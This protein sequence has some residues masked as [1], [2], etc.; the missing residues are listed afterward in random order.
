MKNIKNY[1]FEELKQELKN[2]GEKPFRAEQIYKWLYEEKVKSFEEMTN[3]SKELREKLNNE[4]TI[5][6]FNILRKQESK[7]G[8]VKYLFDVLDGNAIETV[9]MKYHHG[10]S[11]CVSSQ[12]GCKMGCKFCASTGIQFI[13]SLSAGE[14]VE[15]VLAVEQDQNVRISNIVFMGIGE[16]LDNYD[17][18]VKAIR[19]INHP[20]GLNIGARHISI[21]TSGLVPKIYKL[22]EENIQC[23]LS[24]SLHATNNEKRSSMMP[25]NDAYPIEELIKA[26]KDY[27]KITNRRISFEY[28][29]AKDN[30]DNLEDAKEL[31]KLLKGMLCHVNLIPINK[32]E[33]GKFDKSSNENIMK[34]RDYLNDHGI[35]ATIRRELGSDIDAACRTIKKKEFKRRTIMLLDEI[36][37]IL[38]F[39][40]KIKVYA[41]VGPSGTGKSYRAQMVASEKDIHFIIDDG[42]LIKDNEVIAGESAKKAETKVATVKHA[43]FYEDNEKEVIIKALKKYKPDSILILGTS[44]GMVKKIS[45]NLSLPEISETIYITDVA[46]E[47]EMQTARRIRVTEGKHVIPVPTFEIKKD[48]SGYLLDP[49]QIFKSKG[50][51]QKPYISEKSII[52]PTFSYMGKFTISDLVFRQ[53][54][55]YLASQTKAIYKILKTRVENYGEGVNLYMEV[56]IVYGYNVIDGLKSFKEKARKEIEK[57]TAMNVVELEVVAKNIYVPQE[58]NKE[59]K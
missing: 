26:C 41:F 48:F 15:Q 43:L 16:P 45:E 33:N 54:L 31:V 23:T 5:C 10:Y 21:S 53:I 4:Y 22:A 17:N 37:E 13:R 52:R 57:L 12:I 38:P 1:E 39:M 27:I 42:L 9:L 40:K 6:N 35:V 36:K 24:I 11:L 44:D 59:D 2:I 51:G 20:K 32:I 7:D 14:I 28:A 3:L 46:T 47:Q 50:K 30:N 56:T 34:F 29:L 18:V 55:E 19:I 49:L 58:D 25:V 8:T